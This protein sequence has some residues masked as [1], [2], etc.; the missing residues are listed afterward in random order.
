MK[1]SHLCYFLLTALCLASCSSNKLPVGTWENENGYIINL[2]PYE[3]TVLDPMDEQTPCY[4]YINLSDENFMVVLTINKT[5]VQDNLILVNYTSSNDMRWADTGEVPDTLTYHPEEKSL[6][7]GTTTFTYK[8]EESAAN[9]GSQSGGF[10]FWR[11]IL[12]IIGIALL[13][14]AYYLF[15]I[16]LAYVLMTALGAGIGAIIGFLV[17]LPFDCQT[18]TVEIWCWI[19]AIPFG[20]LGLIV[21]LYGTKGFLKAPLLSKMGAELT[22]SEPYDYIITDEHGNKVKAK[23]DGSGLLGEKYY[24]DENGNRYIKEGSSFRR[25]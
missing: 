20:V 4:G 3:T 6:S 7:M 11:I 22:K 8:G 16:I 15:K 5:E 19:F 21:G 13:I 23:K 1:A 2:N 24:I 9:Q 18:K 25:I 14:A 12:V 17:T 10:S